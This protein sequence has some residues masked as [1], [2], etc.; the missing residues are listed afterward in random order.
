MI[1]PKVRGDSAIATEF[2]VSYVRDYTK[3]GLSCLRANDSRQCRQKSRMR[4]GVRPVR[5]RLGGQGPRD[6]PR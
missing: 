4:V 3:M 1:G 2:G 6:E 5:S